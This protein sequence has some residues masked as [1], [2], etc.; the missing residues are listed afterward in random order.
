MKKM[1]ILTPDKGV[2][3]GVLEKLAR[4]ILLFRLT[5]EL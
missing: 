5:Q 2:A 4:G 3:P 1:S